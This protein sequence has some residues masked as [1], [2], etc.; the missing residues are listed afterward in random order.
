VTGV[1]IVISGTVV[2]GTLRENATLLM[3]PGDDGNFKEIVV[4]TIHSK[5][6]AVDKCEAGDS[7]AVSLRASKR[8]EPLKRSQIRRGMVLIDPIARPQAARCFDAEV[9]VLHHPT[10]IKLC[11]QAVIHCGIIRQTAAII[12]IS[13]ECLRTGDKA[14]V[15]FRFMIRPEFV[16]VGSVFIFR[17]GN[18]KGIGKIVRVLYGEEGEMPKKD[19]KE[20]RRERDKDKDKEAGKGKDKE[21]AG[22]DENTNT[23]APDTSST[24]ATP[25]GP[26][27]VKEKENKT[28]KR[29]TDGDSAS[30]LAV[31]KS[32]HSFKANPET[33]KVSSVTSAMDP[34]ANTKQRQIPEAPA[35]VDFKKSPSTDHPSLLVAD[36]DDGEGK[37]AKKKGKNT[38]KKRN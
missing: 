17:E 4:R 25:S 15:K 21:K 13:K 33:K 18:T 32:D 10:T 3:G 30:A 23:S 20:A 34:K 22:D 29:K 8:R 19:G 24:T 9:L 31:K 27:V 35:A 6:V 1:G 5:R 11:Y 26:E 12:S 38:K 28:E 36:D 7:C 16:H 37:R 2:T 14:V